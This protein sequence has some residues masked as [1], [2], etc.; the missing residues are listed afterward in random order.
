MSSPPTFLQRASRPSSLIAGLAVAGLMVAGFFVVPGVVLLTRQ[1]SDGTVPCQVLPVAPAPLPPAAPGALFYEPALSLTFEGTDG[2]RARSVDCK[3]GPD[4]HAPLRIGYRPTPLGIK[5]SGPGGTLAC[6]VRPPVAET[7]EPA[8]LTFSNDAGYRFDVAVECP[9]GAR[10]NRP[11]RIEYHPRDVGLRSFTDTPG[12]FNTT[13]DDGPEP[14]A[15]AIAFAIAAPFLAAIGWR[16]WRTRRVYVIAPVAAPPGDPEPT[17]TGPG[18]SPGPSTTVGPTGPG[19]AFYAGVPGFV[20]ALLGTVAA[21]AMSSLNLAAGLAIAFAV[22][23]AVVVLTRRL[24][25]PGRRDGMVVTVSDETLTLDPPNG[26]AGV[27]RRQDA[28]LVG[29][30]TFSGGKAYWVSGITVWRPDGQVLGSWSPDW[31]VG[32]S[33]KALRRALRSHGWP[34]VDQSPRWKGRLFNYDPGSPSPTARSR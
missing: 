2:A 27:V 25:R 30:E 29:V 22:V 33:S 19:S 6:S 26:A 9:G 20:L 4:S 21:A 24:L 28:G 10:P 3:H 23:V 5:A 18:P 14:A 15:A 17:R 7:T 34:Q 8:V 11:M 32:R 31:P 12:P 13:G 1:A 16:W